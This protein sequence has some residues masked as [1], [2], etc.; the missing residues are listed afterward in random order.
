MVTMTPPG[1]GVGAGVGV[2]VGAG[3]GRG[4]GLSRGVAVGV[5]AGVAVGVGVGVGPLMGEPLSLK[6]CGPLVILP[7]EPPNPKLICPRA[8]IV[9]FHPADLIT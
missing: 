5:G 8:G 3:V 1:T 6:F 9:L 4:V 7:G 2:G